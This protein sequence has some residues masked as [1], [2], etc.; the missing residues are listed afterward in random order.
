MRK[1]VIRI[2]M[3]SLIFFIIKN[4]QIIVPILFEYKEIIGI[5]V[6]YLF[7]IVVVI[8]QCFIKCNDTTGND[9]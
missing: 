1:W 7:A 9:D 2:F 3:F 6:S 5:V 4:I 8:L